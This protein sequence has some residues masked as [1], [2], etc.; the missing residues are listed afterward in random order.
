MIAYMAEIQKSK[1][2]NIKFREFGQSE[3][4]HKQINSVYI[5]IL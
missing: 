1:F 5:F 3:P 2:V 4:S